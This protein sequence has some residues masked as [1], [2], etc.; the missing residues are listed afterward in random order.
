MHHFKMR[1]FLWTILLFGFISCSYEY[2]GSRGLKSFS[3]DRHS[4]QTINQTRQIREKNKFFGQDTTRGIYIQTITAKQKGNVGIYGYNSYS[5][6]FGRVNFFKYKDNIVTF[7]DRSKLDNLQMTIE[8]FL[9]DN[10]FSK[11]QIRTTKDKVKKLWDIFSTD[12]F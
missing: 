2:M 10:N 7:L 11:R 8:N 3:A 4:A 6:H 5:D 9:H 1:Q 12:V